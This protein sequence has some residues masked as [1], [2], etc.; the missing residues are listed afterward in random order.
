MHIIASIS[1]SCH[2]MQILVFG[3][4]FPPPCIIVR[5][6][7]VNMT[8]RSPLLSH[9]NRELDVAHGCLADV[10][11]NSKNMVKVLKWLLPQLAPHYI[12]DHP[13]MISL[14]SKNI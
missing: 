7:K 4:F 11:K 8:K 5:W 13:F 3:S 14:V 2:V 9:Q 12:Q 10:C 6:G 1:F